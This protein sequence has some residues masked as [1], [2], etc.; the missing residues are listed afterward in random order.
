MQALQPEA[1]DGVFL[2]TNLFNQPHGETGLV[3]SVLL[4]HPSHTNTEQHMSAQQAAG[5]Q[6]IP[7]V[8]IKP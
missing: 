3:G 7:L 6:W 8:L 2:V 1:V 5:R 4:L